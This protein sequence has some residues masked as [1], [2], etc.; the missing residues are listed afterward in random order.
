MLRTLAASAARLVL[1][2]FA[3]HPPAHA[4]DSQ[5]PPAVQRVMNRAGIPA[6]NVSIYVRDAGSNDVVLAINDNQPRSPASVI[7]VLT[8]YAAL[9]ALGPSYT[10]KTR[11]YVN[12]RLANGV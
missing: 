1:A 5:L 11:A 4:R 12:G 2:A 10:W 9:Y 3:V 6:R 7:K 8:T